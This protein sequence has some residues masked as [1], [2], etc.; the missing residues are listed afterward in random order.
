M[1]SIRKLGKRR[2]DVRTLS[3]VSAE[4]GAGEVVA[5]VGESG[6]GKTTLLRCLNGLETFDEGAA[7]I[8]GFELDPGLRSLSEPDLIRLRGA[9]GFAFQEH[10]LFPHLTAEENVSLSPRVVKHVPAREARE[11]AQE[12]LRAVGLAERAGAYPHQLS[13]GQRQRVAL[14]RA[15][16][17]DPKVLLLDEPTSALDPETAEGV[18]RTILDVTAGR[19]T[20][21]LVTHQISLAHRMAGRVLRLEG[22]ALAELPTPTDT[23]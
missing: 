6:C 2:G 4:I 23:R 5:I 3:G 19:V 14:A 21:V 20:V 16:A 7:T 22:G 10:H 18:A 8:A 12:L 15:L 13:G 1:I 17:Q 9:V 11:R